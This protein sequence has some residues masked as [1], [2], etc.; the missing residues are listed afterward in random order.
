MNQELPVFEPF[1]G[2]HTLKAVTD[3]LDIGWLGMGAFTKQFEEDIAA[4]LGTP[5]RP[6]LAT[7]TG[8]SALHLALLVAGVGQGDEVIVPS[9]NFVAD[10]QAITAVGAQPVFCDVR[11]DNLGM[12]VDKAAELVSSR[13][14]AILPL[15]YA[16]IPCDLDGVYELAKLH[17]LRVIED[18]THAFGST[19][20]GRPI[21]SFGDLTCFSFDPVKVVTAIDGGAVVCRNQEEL[22]RLQ[23][24]R[25]LGIDKDTVERYKNQRAW[26]YDVVSEGF[27]YHMTNINASIGL[28]QL[29]RAGDFIDSRRETCRF[30]NREL[31]GLDGIQTPQT[32]FS[33]VSAFIYFIRVRPDWRLDLIDFLRQRGVATGIH[34]MPAH[35]YTLYANCRHGNMD[36]TD[37]VTQEQVTL[38]LHSHMP[39]EKAERVVAGLKAFVTHR[40]R[41]A[42]PA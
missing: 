27:R 34:F 19:Y 28:S 8:T 2:V 17:G 10:H 39:I 32:D 7:N 23:H 35:R 42:V 16:G 22:T 24:Y 18:A 26:E 11:S 21:G 5:E 9:F 6:V 30:Y 37:Q 15:H 31:A 20:H 14:K 36:V 3:A 29:A 38:P 13:T 25:L 41:S 4:F 1:I 33:D 40:A 12:D